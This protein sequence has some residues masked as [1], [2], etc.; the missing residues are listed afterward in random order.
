M[1]PCIL[2]HVVAVA[3]VHLLHSKSSWP[4]MHMPA[5]LAHPQPT[6]RNKQSSK[7]ICVKAHAW[8]KPQ[9]QHA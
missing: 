1:L 7:E 3:R 5:T 8:S 9:P 4:G 2:R 6:V